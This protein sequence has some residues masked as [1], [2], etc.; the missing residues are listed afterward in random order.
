MTGT[1]PEMELGRSKYHRLSVG[2][3]RKSPGDAGHTSK[4][5]SE[6]DTNSKS[7][8]SVTLHSGTPRHLILTSSLTRD[9][10]LSEDWDQ[11]DKTKG[12][13]FPVSVS[14]PQLNTSPTKLSPLLAL[15]I[16]KATFMSPK[17]VKSPTFADP[18]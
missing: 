12:Q 11:S 5:Y 15:S 18:L 14:A 6:T 10:R 4:L 1:E 16:R 9:S 8:T 17:E 7:Y 3:Q 2:K 13:E